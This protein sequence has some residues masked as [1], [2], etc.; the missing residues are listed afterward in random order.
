MEKRRTV[1]ISDSPREREDVVSLLERLDLAEVDA[2]SSPEEVQAIL[3]QNEIIDLVIIDYELS[4]TKGWIDPLHELKKEYGFHLIYLADFDSPGDMEPV[5]K[6]RPFSILSKPVDPLQLETVIQSLF[7]FLDR[8][9]ELRES[10]KSLRIAFD[11]SND[12]IIW[13]EA[14]TGIIV[15]CNPSAER[16]L[17]RGRDQIIGL[18]QSEIHPETEREADREHFNRAEEYNRPDT[19]IEAHIQRP[20][21]TLRTVE[22]VSTIFERHGVS[23]VQGV[24][25]DVTARKEMACQ[26]EENEELFRVIAESAQLY[27]FLF[28]DGEIIFVNDALC[29]AYGYTREELMGSGFQSLLGMLHPEERD[30]AR[31]EFALLENGQKQS[32]R[33]QLRI[34]NKNG[35]L[36]HVDHYARIVDFQGK[37]A[38]LVTQADLTTILETGK[39][40]EVE[41][42]RLSAII[43]SSPD[44]IIVADSEGRTVRSN[45]RAAQLH[46]YEDPDELLGISTIDLI[47]PDDRDFF[48]R[49]GTELV[50]GK[51]ATTL[52][53]SLIRKDGTSFP[54]EMSLAVLHENGEVSGFI[55][56]ARDVSVK[57]RTLQELR[58][59]NER[60]RLLYDNAPMAYLVTDANGTITRANHAARSLLKYPEGELVDLD[61]Q[62][63]FSA[64]EKKNER[65]TYILS[66]IREGGHIEQEETWLYDR[67]G[68][69][70]PV[71]LSLSSITGPKSG[72]LRECYLTLEDITDRK[73]VEEHLFRAKLEADAAS[74]AKSLFL[75]KV[76][77]ELRTPLNAILGFGQILEQEIGENLDKTHRS[78]LDDILQGGNQLLEMI[79]KILELTHLESGSVRL[80]RAP[81]DLPLMINRL[82]VELKPRAKERDLLLTMEQDENIQWILADEEKVKQALRNILHNAIQYS[83]RESRIHV[84][85]Q[86]MDY[87]AVIDVHDRGVPIPLQKKEEIFAPFEQLGR[88]M[89]NPTPGYGLGLPMAR[90]IA[91]LHEGSLH[92][93][94]SGEEG[95]TFRM[96]LPGL[97]TRE[98]SQT[99]DLIEGVLVNQE[100]FGSPYQILLVDGN[101]Q[102][103]RQ[104]EE[105]L[106]QVGYRVDRADSGES[107]FLKVIR[108]KYDLIIIASSLPGMNSSETLN[109]IR[110]TDHVAVP[111]IAIT[112]DRDAS[113]KTLRQGFDSYITRPVNLSSLTS[114]IL[115]LLERET[116]H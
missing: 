10:E 5:R 2:L 31:K 80:S 30:L 69:R 83:P 25:R 102:S 49:N 91:E 99:H 19:P 76:S 92:L 56:I 59:T 112:D 13:A 98:Q 62:V 48:M 106:R 68:N 18:H 67:E 44:G 89:D 77:H 101:L 22:I 39:R 23:I 73:Q 26:L 41:Q 115:H 75:S 72:T 33:V 74:Q 9:V 79:E 11:Q 93:V 7:R 61:I 32:Y 47:H 29:R 42:E 45:L 110:T 20:D 66:Y 70:V 34:I 8:E 27:L 43:H 95:N 37:P 78:Y 94:D 109:R 36:L 114:R 84:T 90:R 17:G 96:I 21:G 116:R 97:Y 64:D 52:T 35:Q 57:Y 58:K 55:G 71:L 63:L 53:I 1:I 100:N 14:K 15:E 103:S 51:G 108:E 104:M 87:M 105:T 54:A 12:A 38:H 111:I 82:L 113:E 40:L 46:G 85:C 24:F 60:F 107:A 3:S 50:N 65:G 81:F 88:R 28:Q 16:L 86:A 4:E 6:T